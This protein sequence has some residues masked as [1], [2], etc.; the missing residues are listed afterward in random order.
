MKRA[1][2]VDFQIF[3][4]DMQFVEISL[5]PGE[6]IVAEAGAMMYID[7]AIYMDTVFGDGSDKDQGKGFM[8]KMLGAGKRALT[9]ESLFM[10]TYTNQGNA[11]KAVAFAA[12]YPGKVIPVDLGDYQGQ[13]ICQRDTFLCAAKGIELEIAFQKN[14]GAGLFG[15]EGFILQKLIGAG[16]AFLHAGGT[17]IQK[18]LQPGETLKMD[19]GCLVAMTAGVN[20]DIA[21]ASNIKSAIFGGEGLVLATLQGPGHVWMQSIPFSRFANRVISASKKSGSGSNSGEG[22]LVGNIGLKNLLGRD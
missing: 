20:Y 6:T 21:F 12:P 7:N 13:L 11:K 2:E 15:G 17:I 5:D 18:E 10:T 19:T 1:H 14:I 3:G 4:D 8:D 22:G 16:L 9:G